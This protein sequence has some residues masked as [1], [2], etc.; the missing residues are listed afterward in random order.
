MLFYC[1][2]D[3]GRKMSSLAQSFDSLRRSSALLSSLTYPNAAVLPRTVLSSVGQFETVSLRE[4]EPHENGL[5]QPN[6]PNIETWGAPIEGEDGII[7]NDTDK[8]T[9]TKRRAPRRA[10]LGKEKPSPLKENHRQNNKSATGQNQSREDPGRCL[11][12]AQKL[13]QV[14]PLPQESGHVEALHAQW[15]GVIDS[16]ADLEETLSQP[17]ARTG[18]EVQHDESYYRLLSLEDEI[19]R[20]HLELLALEQFK[21]DREAELAALKPAQ[22]V[23]RPGAA[24]RKVPSVVARS[25]STNPASASVPVRR[26][27]IKNRPSTTSIDSSEAVQARQ[28]RSRASTPQAGE[29]PEEEPT[30]TRT[31]TRVRP[32]IPSA[33]PTPPA[34]ASKRKS[35]GTTSRS[36]NQVAKESIPSPSPAEAVPAKKT[37]PDGVTEEEMVAI[38]K[39]VWKLMGEGLKPWGKKWVRDQGIERNV[40]EDGLDIKETI[41]T[42]ESALSSNLAQDPQSPSSASINSYATSQGGNDNDPS[43]PPPSTM[44]ELKLLHLFL[45]VFSS[46]PPPTFSSTLPPLNIVLRDPPADSPCSSS[47]PPGSKTP[48][49]QMNALKA[50]L[51][52]FAVSRGWT[53]GMGTTSIY[54][55]ISKQVARIDRRG[56]EGAC[57]GFKL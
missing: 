53:E 12:A 42:L 27:P 49:L 10:D 25:Q 35:I 26:A 24:A 37:L 38:G 15:L 51:G 54:A 6:R 21:K 5:F 47:L 19:K 7:M 43:A 13:L 57:V 14:Y 3:V 41:K 52:A 2:R 39:L 4:V 9:A 36:T 32:S 44:V 8:W 31:S 30:A 50:H 28:A 20:E 48:T 17:L 1:G 45:T 29:K 55:L 40:E 18:P 16:I 11:K 56:K 33:V 46:V 22:P 34:V 23:R